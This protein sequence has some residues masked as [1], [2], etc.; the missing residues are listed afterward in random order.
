MPEPGDRPEPADKAL[1]PALIELFRG[2][3]VDRLPTEEV[4]AALAERLG[5]P[6]TATRLAR[7]LGPQGVAPRQYRASGQRVRG[8]LLADLAES[9]DAALSGENLSD[10]SCGSDLS[11][12]TRDAEAAVERHAAAVA[13][14]PVP[15][16]FDR[17][18]AE[19]EWATR[20]AMAAM[21]R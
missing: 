12:E 4:V 15:N 10:E 8:Y 1:L 2:R 14:P 20:L 9:R 21:G 16:S 6:I 13:A 5:R 3:G 19:Q 17:L 11:G 7:T 18:D